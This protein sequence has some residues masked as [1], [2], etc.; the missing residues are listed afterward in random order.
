MM[1][2]YDRSYGGDFFFFGGSSSGFGYYLT[3]GNLKRKI[4]AITSGDNYYNNDIK[5][6]GWVPA[7]SR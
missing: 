3:K 5:F 4:N 1:S 2:D 6:I 7:Q